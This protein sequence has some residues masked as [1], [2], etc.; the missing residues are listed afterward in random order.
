M[1]Q[2]ERELMSFRTPRSAAEEES[3]EDVAV[4][5]GAKSPGSDV[6]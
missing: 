4:A 6:L 5:A 3:K 1:K 2:K